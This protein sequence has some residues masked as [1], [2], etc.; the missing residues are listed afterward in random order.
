M[1]SQPAVII[2]RT[3]Y[4]EAQKRASYKW[5]SLNPDKVAKGNRV[6]QSKLKEKMA[7]FTELCDMRLAIQ[8]P[9]F[10]PKRKYVRKDNLLKQLLVV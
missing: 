8:H 7:P 6:Y 5:R 9:E 10:K 1:I 2:I 4:T 3:S